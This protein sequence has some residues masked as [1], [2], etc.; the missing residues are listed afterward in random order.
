MKK[1]QL[2]TGLALLI[3]LTMLGACKKITPEKP[4]NQAEERGHDMPYSTDFIFTPCQVEGT[5]GMFVDKIIDKG[6][7]FTWTF[8]NEKPNHEPIALKRGTWY[9][10]QVVLKNFAGESINDQYVTPEQALLHQ[11]FLIS[12]VLKE[13]NKKVYRTIESNIV[14]KY[15][16][17]LMLEGKRNPIGF[18]G[19]FQVLDSATPDQFFLNII[20][21]H[22]LPPATK[23][24]R[25]E[26]TFYPFDKPSRTMGTR[27]LELYIPVT[28]K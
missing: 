3:V 16:E 12:K 10:L 28:L 2:C 1:L 17:T 18:D 9:H 5:G 26:N 27:D 23:I 4:I 22:V 11:F 24:N 14:Y 6:E 19:A 20:L 13:D 25:K 8:S 7:S 15:A 21:V